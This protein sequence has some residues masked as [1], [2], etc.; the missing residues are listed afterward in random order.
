MAKKR[1]QPSGTSECNL[2]MTPMIDVTFQL[3]AFFMFVLNVD[4]AEQNQAIRLPASDLAKPPEK[5]VRT[6]L[7][8]HITRPQDDGQSYVYFANR[9]MLP[10][11]DELKAAIEK[12]RQLLLYQHKNPEDPNIVVL[13]RGDALARWRTDVERVIEQW[14]DGG[15]VNFALRAKQEVD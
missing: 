4:D 13:V 15:F 11:S 1:I 2:D 10:G 5:L 6:V 7:T 8:V 9:R 3:I 12:E 14:Q